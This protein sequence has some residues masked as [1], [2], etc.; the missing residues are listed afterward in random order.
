MLAPIVI[1]AEIRQRLNIDKAMF[2]DW[3]IPTRIINP[4]IILYAAIT[5]K[6]FLTTPSL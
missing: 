5:F 1:T 2:Q 4:I 3:N 6:F